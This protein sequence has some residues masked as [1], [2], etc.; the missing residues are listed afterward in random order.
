MQTHKDTETH[1]VSDMEAIIINCTTRMI[2]DMIHLT[3]NT[4]FAYMEVNHFRMDNL[5]HIHMVNDIITGMDKDTMD[6]MEQATVTSMDQDTTD[7]IEMDMEE[8]TARMV[9]LVDK[10]TLVPMD[11]AMVPYMEQILHYMDKFI[12]SDLL[13]KTRVL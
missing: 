11:K 4:T 6:L 2:N 5:T 1:T 7:L 12:R 3:T 10:D 8:F 9:A 13:H